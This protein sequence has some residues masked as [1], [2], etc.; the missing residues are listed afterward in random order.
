MAPLERVPARRE[1]ALDDLEHLAER[2]AARTRELDGVFEAQRLERGRGVPHLERERDA[3]ADR[4]PRRCHREPADLGAD[5]VPQAEDRE[6]ADVTALEQRAAGVFQQ[7]IGV[8]VPA[9]PAGRDR[10]QHVRMILADVVQ[11]VG[12]A[13]PHV[14]ARVGLEDLED[15]EHGT[16]IALERLQRHAPRQARPAALARKTAHV[17]V[18]VGRPSPHLSHRRHGVAHDE[19][20]DREL[21]RGV[22][23]HELQR[24]QRASGVVAPEHLHEVGEDEGP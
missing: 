9:V 24:G 22:A 7:P 16:G 15:L 6:R 18:V 20:P 17:L 1:R 4:H 14:L 21:S 13:A 8:G 10:E 12:D 3:V 11:V 5:V 19:R 23:R 2:L